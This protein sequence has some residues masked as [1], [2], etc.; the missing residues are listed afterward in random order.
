MGLESSASAPGNRRPGP[1]CPP[2]VR[3]VI[4]GQPAACAPRVRR[5]GGVA[6]RGDAAPHGTSP[7]D[8]GERVGLPRRTAPLAAATLLL[9]ALATPAAG[10]VT[11]GAAGAS[12]GTG[13]A[14][15][16]G[17]SPLASAC[18]SRSDLLDGSPVAR[19]RAAGGVTVTAWNGTDGRGHDVRVTAAQ[20]SV[21][22][23]RLAGSA[24]ARFRA[25]PPAPEPT[26][27]AR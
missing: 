19:L 5:E 13:P 6:G 12:A 16:A 18:P 15:D 27:A 26:A 11:A 14:A 22:R 25:A 23:V 7:P 20:A 10:K 3:G 4:H 9:A 21:A 1:R 17:R 2:A 8:D 24:P